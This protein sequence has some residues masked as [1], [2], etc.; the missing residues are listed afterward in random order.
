[1]IWYLAKISF[2]QQDDKG[3]NRVVTQDYLFDAVSYTDAE[4]RAYAYCAQELQEFKVSSITKQKYNEIFYADKDLTDCGYWKVKT[5]Y[6][7]FD[8]RSQKEKKVPFLFLVCA[9]DLKE[10]HD[11]TVEKLG[12]VQDYRVEAITSTNLLDIIR[13]GGVQS[14][15]KEADE[16]KQDPEK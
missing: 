6:I 8:E 11:V 15:E 16:S 9:D 12:K 2:I 14:E 5:N 4:T 10:A 1:M 3:N 13:G 7:V